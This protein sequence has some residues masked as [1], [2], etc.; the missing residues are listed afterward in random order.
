MRKTDVER[1]RKTGSPW[2]AGAVLLGVILVGIMAL[3]SADQEEGAA[4][5]VP[6]VADTH[7]PAAVP[8]PPYTERV[9]TGT[10]QPVPGTDLPTESTD[11]AGESTTGEATAREASRE[12][13]D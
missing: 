9:R 8:R 1:K 4:V 10:D 3:M 7:P 12:P 5:D 6:T 13:Q 11:G 2:I